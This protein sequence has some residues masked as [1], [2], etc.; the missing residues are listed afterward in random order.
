MKETEACRFSAPAIS[1]GEQGGDELPRRYL[2]DGVATPLPACFLE[3]AGGIRHIYSLLGSGG[4]RVPSTT[5]PLQHTS[6]EHSQPSV[7][8]VLYWGDLSTPP[9]P[10]HTSHIPWLD[11]EGRRSSS[12]LHV[13]IGQQRAPFS[14]EH[15][16]F[17]GT[18]S[19]GK[20]ETQV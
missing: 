12:L 17:A 9:R 5:P 3:G 18:Q 16:S 15:L 20:H 8:Q 2:E 4:S 1:F 10:I 14:L 19:K 6:V 13:F 7:L 11:S